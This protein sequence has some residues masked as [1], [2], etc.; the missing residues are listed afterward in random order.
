MVQINVVLGVVIDLV[1]FVFYLF[2]KDPF[3]FLM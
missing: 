1:A 2:S 3:P